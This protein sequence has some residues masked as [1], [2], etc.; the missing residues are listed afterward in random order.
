MELVEKENNFIQAKIRANIWAYTYRTLSQQ[1]EQATGSTLKP[2]IKV[3]FNVSINF[4]EGK[5]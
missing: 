3:L 1:F 4:H 5:V 2:G